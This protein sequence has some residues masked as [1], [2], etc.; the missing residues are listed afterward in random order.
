M[1]M[2]RRLAL[3]VLTL[4]LMLNGLWVICHDVPPPPK[5]QETQETAQSQSPEDELKAECEKL[6]AR[7]SSL[8]LISPGDKTSLS[9]VI[10]GVAIFPS[11][12]QVS[13]TAVSREPVAQVRNLY[14]DPTIAQPSPPPEA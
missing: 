2:F 14:S 4:P 7:Q 6:C 10:L 5:T 11:D 13:S 12:L 3:C 1:N 8:C 9:I